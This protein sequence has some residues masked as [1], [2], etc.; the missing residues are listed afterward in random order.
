MIRGSQFTVLT[1]FVA[2]FVVAVLVAF[3]DYGIVLVPVLE[4][5]MVYFGVESLLRQLP[6]RVVQVANNNCKRADGSVSPRRQLGE[7][8]ALRK[9]RWNVWFIFLMVLMTSS[10]TV[11]QILS[12]FHSLPDLARGVLDPC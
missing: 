4:L 6:P 9:L 10:S 3:H 2:M 5:V 7:K 11:V 12:K 1:L 8:R